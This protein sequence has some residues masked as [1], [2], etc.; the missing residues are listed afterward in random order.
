M[1]LPAVRGV[2]LEELVLH[3][4]G[5][6]GFRIVTSGEE[7]THRGHAGLVKLFRDMHF[8]TGGTQK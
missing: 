3:L 7:G 6:V 8:H 2:L 4:L 5:L 1:Q